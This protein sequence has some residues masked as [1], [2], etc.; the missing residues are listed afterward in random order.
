MSSRDE[1]ASYDSVVG[2]AVRRALKKKAD[3]ADWHV[4]WGS[5]QGEDKH[6]NHHRV[7]TLTNKTSG[8]TC[9]IWTTRPDIGPRGSV[10]CCMSYELREPVY[11]YPDDPP[12]FDMLAFLAVGQ[13]ALSF[14]CAEEN[15]LPILGLESSVI[16]WRP[17]SDYLAHRLY[18]TMTGAELL[19]EVVKGE[20][21]VDM[22]WW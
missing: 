17:E 13:F 5:S 2:K 3:A 21:G 19:E 7:A 16:L 10:E 22:P 6:E 8:D 14:V 20:G 15:G 11:L 18:V 1:A 4:R 9:T 12:V